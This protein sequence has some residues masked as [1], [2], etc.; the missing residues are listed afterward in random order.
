M[1]QRRLV[2][3]L[4]ALTALAFTISACKK[5]NQ[6]PVIT[7]TTPLEGDTVLIPDSIRISGTVGDDVGLHQSAVLILN[8]NGDTVVKQY[9][10][11]HDLKAYPFAY[12]FFPAVTGSYTLKIWAED[13]QNASSETSVNFV[14]N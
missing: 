11:V 2:I 3:L 10:Y 4:T 12:N 7:I 6:P 14:A 9:P 1:K 13:H 8:A 5:R